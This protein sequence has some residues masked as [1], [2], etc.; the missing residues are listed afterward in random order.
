VAAVVSPF[1]YRRWFSREPF[2][3]RFVKASLEGSLH[4]KS[5]NS[6]T[7]YLPESASFILSG[8]KDNR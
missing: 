1:F 2:D 8:C 5:A 6:L 7:I 4:K 3:E